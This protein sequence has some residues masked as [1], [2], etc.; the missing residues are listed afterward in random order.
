ME[1]KKIK[2]VK[3]RDGRI[4]PF[5]KD[6]I[7]E[8]IFKAAKS[9]GGEN[10]YLAEDLAEAVTLYLE[11]N[12]K[13]KIPSV[14]EIQDIVERVLI[15]TGHAKTAKAYILYRQKRANVRKV[16]EGIKPEELVERERERIKYIR[17]INISVQRSDE[18]LTEW[19]R[20]RIINALLKETGISRNIAEIIVSEVEEEVISSKLKVITSPI[21][22]ELVNAKLV[23]YGFEEE[24]K[25]HARLGIPLYDIKQFFS[26]FNGSPDE[27]SMKFGKHIKK[28]FALSDVFSSDVVL[29]H[30]KGEIFLHCLEDIDKFYSF[31][32]CSELSKEEMKLIRDYCCFVYLEKEIPDIPETRTDKNSKGKEGTFFVILLPDG[33]EGI[34]KFIQERDVDVELMREKERENLI[35][36][37]ITLNTEKITDRDKIFSLIKKAFEEKEEFIESVL[38]E[39]IKKFFGK[40]NRKYEIEVKG[41]YDEILEDLNSFNGYANIKLMTDVE[42]FIKYSELVKGTNVRVAGKVNKESLEFLKGIKGTFLKVKI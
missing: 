31:E 40:F 21:I 14:E 29:S 30:F 34:Y 24:R 3:K 20:D 25:K 22:R 18:V 8:A 17:N 37:K 28:E 11:K 27:L 12:F 4:V 5:E 41:E 9:V 42:K 19:N 10:R 13:G 23:Q 15:K 33:L 6:K 2:S 16:R 7:T 26:H 35:V 32:T 39:N 38:D 1:E 36:Q